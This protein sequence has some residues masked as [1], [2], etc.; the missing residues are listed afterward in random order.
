MKI[1]TS[2]IPA[3]GSVLEENISSAEL[4]LD[5]ELVRLQGPL[6]VRAVFSR[7]TNAITV[8]LDL[9]AVMELFCVRCLKEYTLDFS[10]SLQLNYSVDKGQLTL[11]INPDIREEVILDYPLKPL[12]RLECKGLCLKCGKNLNE[13]GCSCATT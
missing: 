2:K 6:K 9:S 5:T 1:D 4:D 3:E 8:Q 12:C 10:K 7:I 11:D 13:G